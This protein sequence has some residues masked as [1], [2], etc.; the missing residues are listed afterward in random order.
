MADDYKLARHQRK[1]DERKRV[2]P[3]GWPGDT[4]TAIPTDVSYSP[5]ASS[6]A[7]AAE[8]AM[9]DEDREPA[10]EKEVKPVS[11]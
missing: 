2:D 3:G 10:R 5:G 9:E 7:E 8:A 1:A 11:K 6:P 4:H